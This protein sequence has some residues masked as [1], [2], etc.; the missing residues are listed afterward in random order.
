MAGLGVLANTVPRKCCS[1]AP[2]LPYPD[3][4]VLAGRQTFAQFRDLR[5]GTLFSK[6]DVSKKHCFSAVEL[7]FNLAVQRT[8]AVENLRVGVGDVT[9]RFSAPVPPVTCGTLCPFEVGWSLV[10][11]ALVSVNPVSDTINY[12]GVGARNKSD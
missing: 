11:G 5:R 1:S 3:V 7:V 9:L 4:E 6:I 10:P 2:L 8:C 12:Y